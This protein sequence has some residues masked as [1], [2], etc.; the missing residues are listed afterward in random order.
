MPAIKRF[1]S[2]V[3]LGRVPAD[4]VA[5]HARSDTAERGEAGSH[6]RSS[7]SRAIRD[8]EA[9]AAHGANHPRSLHERGRHRPGLLPRAAAR[10]PRLR[11][12]WAGGGLALRCEATRSRRTHC[13]GSRRWS[14]ATTPAE[15]PMSVGWK[16]GGGFRV[17]DVA[18]SMFE[19]DAGLVFLAR[20]MTN[21][22]LAEAT[23]AQLGFEYEVCRRS[24]AGR[25]APASPSIDGVVN[26]AVV[27]IIVSA[28]GEGE[29][30]V[31][32][33]TGIDTDARPI[34]RELRPGSTLRKI[35][36]AL[37]D[38]YRSSR[39]LGLDL[40]AVGEPSSGRSADGRP[41]GHDVAVADLQLFEDAIA[42]IA[43]R[44]DLREPNADAVRT[45][46]AEVSQHYDVEERQPP[47]EAV[48]D[49]AT[50]VGK[51]YIL[52]G[53]MELLR[54]RLRRPRL[55]H[56]DPGSDDPRE[57]AGQL[58]AGPSEEPARAD[59]LPAGRRS[60]QRTSTRRR[61]GRRWTTIRRSR[62][63]SS[64]SSRS[65]SRSR[66][67]AARRTSS[68]RAWGPSSTPTSRQRSGSSCSPTSTT[69]TTAR[70]SRRRSATSTHGCWSG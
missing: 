21:G 28:L 33:G 50:G 70:R 19:A 64:P 17:L 68:R 57:D 20:W 60:R 42:E 5:I 43:A 32:C 69:A 25:D 4:L 63:T 37:L 26:E 10:P 48:I 16:G 41:G 27:R 14:T 9:G 47:F 6:E 15:S 35:P 39:Q 13:H 40:A 8:T 22:K 34:L 52:A 56:R 11:T 55:R 51:T 7:R 1:L 3:K 53:A 67:S 54:R 31:V 62:S 46:A 49:S 24:S 2:E 45:L 65:S 59:E 23:A 12:R 58:H 29:R 18:P 36:A 66:R 44:L 38:E 30:V 61:C